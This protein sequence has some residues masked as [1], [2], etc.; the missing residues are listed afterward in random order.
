MLLVYFSISFC[1][2]A[3]LLSADHE[4]KNAALESLPSLDD[5]G[6]VKVSFCG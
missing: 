1:V 2:C 3:L 6:F 4:F 5:F